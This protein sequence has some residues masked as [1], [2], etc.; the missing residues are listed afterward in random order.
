[1][2]RRHGRARR[3]ARRRASSPPL[4]KPMRLMTARPGSRRNRRGADCRAA[5]AASRCRSRQSRS[6]PSSASGTCASLSKP[7]ARPTGFAKSRPHSRCP[8]MGRSGSDLCHPIRR[9][10]PLTSRDAPSREGS[11]RNSG[12]YKPNRDGQRL[13][14][15]RSSALPSSSTSTMAWSPAAGEL[16]RHH[17]AGHHDHAAF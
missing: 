10:A 15:R 2:P 7:A 11:A 8:K 9:R 14:S 13:R 16:D 3:G 4:L 6:R 1:M 12:R 17:A 5:D